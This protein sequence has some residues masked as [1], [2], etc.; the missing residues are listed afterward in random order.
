MALLDSIRDGNSVESIHANP[1]VDNH[2]LLPQDDDLDIA[3]VF[4]RALVE[5]TT[6]HVQAFVRKATVITL[7][8]PELEKY[9]TTFERGHIVTTAEKYK[10]LFLHAANLENFEQAEIYRKQGG[11]SPKELVLELFRKDKA[12]RPVMQLL[13]Q[14]GIAFAQSEVTLPFLHSLIACHVDANNI[15]INNLS[16]LSWALQTENDHL[17]ALAIRSKSRFCENIFQDGTALLFFARRLEVS[18]ETVSSLQ[19][20]QE[21]KKM[22]IDL[23]AALAAIISYAA[24]T[25]DVEILSFL[26][27]EGFDTNAP[28]EDQNTPLHIAL[29]K[30]H[31]KFARALLANGAKL[32]VQNAKGI[33]PLQLLLSNNASEMQALLLE[34]E[35]CNEKIPL[36]ALNAALRACSMRDQ[37]IIAQFLEIFV[38]K[39]PLEVFYTPEGMELFGLFC[40]FGAKEA[41][42]CVMEQGY[43]IYAPQAQGY[44]LFNKLIEQKNVLTIALLYVSDHVEQSKKTADGTPI[45]FWLVAQRHNSQPLKLVI[46][47]GLSF[48]QLGSENETL[49]HQATKNQHVFNVQSLLE[50]HAIDVNALDK[51]GRSALFYALAKGGNPEVIAQL[52]SAG[53]RPFHLGD[54]LLQYTNYILNNRFQL[55]AGSTHLWNRFSE[56][57][58][59]NFKVYINKLSAHEL[60]LYLRQEALEI[61]FFLPK[62]LHNPLAIFSTKEE[63]IDSL[64]QLQKKY[65]DA[66]NEF[67]YPFLALLRHDHLERPVNLQKQT[68]QTLEEKFT[69][70][71]GQF[72]ELVNKR[73]SG[74]A[75][76]EVGTPV[77]PE[78]VVHSPHHH[79][80]EELPSQQGSFDFAH[81]YDVRSVMPFAARFLKR[82][83]EI[84]KEAVIS[85][86]TSNMPEGFTSTVVSELEWA[87]CCVELLYHTPEE[88][89]RAQQLLLSKVSNATQ[90]KTSPETIL[91]TIKE[92]EFISSFVFEKDS[93]TV[94]PA[95]LFIFLEKQLVLQERDLGLFTDFFKKK[96]LT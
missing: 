28:F 36:P 4:K 67:F 46:K 44:S 32:D 24:S 88:Q 27:A 96:A 2:Q 52:L 56:S 45:L 1:A 17:I 57:R 73:V 50:T 80:Q 39:L 53:A 81:E 42:S 37:G 22:G 95:A 15:S 85:W 65:P 38:K 79:D 43:D 19:V 61:A 87:S 86:F 84:D 29:E 6:Q 78:I 74:A 55:I 66:P 91:K 41:L 18:A 14:E 49:L 89:K 16:L 92:Q 8:L 83:I 12:T 54:Q 20:L 70:E 30:S 77:S 59:E 62:L 25:D 60:P 34:P 26:H 5:S 13:T 75:R 94:S 48:N 23:K 47:K 82:E 11:F 71:L 51:Y 10:I 68:G 7:E 21:L 64:C 93:T 31:A 69:N 63:Y 40:R 58:E 9:L 3:S 90:K 76:K 72:R 33:T 35:I